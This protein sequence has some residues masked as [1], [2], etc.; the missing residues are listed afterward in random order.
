MTEQPYWFKRLQQELGF[1]HIAHLGVVIDLDA[2][3]DRFLIAVLQRLETR[4]RAWGG[5][6]LKSADRMSQAGGLL[7]QRL[8]GGAAA[9]LSDTINNA[10]AWASCT[11][12]SERAA[13]NAERKATNLG[14][15]GDKTEINGKI[16]LHQQK[17]NDGATCAHCFPRI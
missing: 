14:C 4:R 8:A 9:E 13:W 12:R 2:T 3:R 17:S 11:A 1:V 10:A 15:A 5:R 16:Q 7:E 6:D